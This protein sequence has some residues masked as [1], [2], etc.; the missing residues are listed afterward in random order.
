MAKLLYYGTC[1]SHDPTK[2]VFPFLFGTT[3]KEAGHE[4]EIVVMGEAV[5]LMKERVAAATHAVGLP[6]A[7]ELIQ[8]AAKLGIPVYV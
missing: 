7:D 6:T 5:F 8:K 2:A 3:A 4:V 1:G